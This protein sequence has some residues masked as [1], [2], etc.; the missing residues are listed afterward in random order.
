[1]GSMD[2][3]K[4]MYFLVTD[5]KNNKLIDTLYFPYIPPLSFGKHYNIKKYDSV[6]GKQFSTYGGYT[7]EN[8]NLSK[9]AR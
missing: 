9:W 1:M 5:F 4:K 7:L 6:N 3:T 8:F 2:E